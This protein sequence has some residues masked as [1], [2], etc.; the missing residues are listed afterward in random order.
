MNYTIEPKAY[1]KLLLHSLKHSKS[2][3]IGVLLGKKQDRSVTVTDAIPLFHNKVMSGML[4]VAFD[5]IEKT[6]VNEST[7]IV[8]VYEAPLFPGVDVPSPLGH[9]IAST[10]K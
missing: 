2:D 7:K 9:T 3:C 10:I 4:E 6:C 8:G 1:K 5:M